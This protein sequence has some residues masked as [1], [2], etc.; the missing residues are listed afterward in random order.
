M[1]AGWWKA[2]SWLAVP[3]EYLP[4]IGYVIYEDEF[5]V[6]AGFLYFP[7]K[8]LAWTD[9]MVANPEA[10]KEQK[11]KAFPIL[12]DLV[13]SVA[14]EMGALV[15]FTGAR[16]G[17]PYQKRAQTAGFDVADEE[18]VHLYKRLSDA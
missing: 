7:S 11:D 1:L 12:F 18:M 13:E 10:T 15:M 2:R 5:P 4:E 14:K 6:L 16:K 8:T 9:W 3:E 17:H